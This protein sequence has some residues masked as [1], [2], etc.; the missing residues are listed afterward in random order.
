MSLM[1]VRHMGHTRTAA[2]ARRVASS[3]HRQQCPHGY[4]S[5]RAG[6]ARQTTQRAGASSSGRARCAAECLRALHDCACCCWW[7]C[8]TGFDL[9]VVLLVVGRAV[10]RPRGPVGDAASLPGV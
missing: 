7:P 5:I 2:S 4:T 9:H 1:S 6:R 8:G 10:L 3:S